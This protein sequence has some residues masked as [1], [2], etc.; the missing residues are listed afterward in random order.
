MTSK[1][2]LLSKPHQDIASWWTSISHDPRFDQLYLIMGVDIAKNCQS[3]EEV[4]AAMNVLE[5]LKTI[6]DNPEQPFK[7]PSSGVIHDVPAARK[8]FNQ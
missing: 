2:L 5:S 1:D 4:R 6:A 8:P 3:I 7:G